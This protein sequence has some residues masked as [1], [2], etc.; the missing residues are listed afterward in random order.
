MF[1]QVIDLPTFNEVSPLSSVTEDRPRGY[2][3]KLTKGTIIPGFINAAT[4]QDR[5]TG[6]I[7][8]LGREMLGRGDGVPDPSNSTLLTCDRYGNVL[9]RKV[10]V[11]PNKLGEQF[12][13]WRADPTN[14]GRVVLGATWTAKIAEG[15][16]RPQMA[17]TEVP[18]NWD[19]QFGEI[20]LVPEA[21]YGK[22]VTP[23][24]G[25]K[26][27]LF[28][29]DR[30]PHVL[31][32]YIIGGNGLVYAGEVHMPS[33]VRERFVKSG[34]TF[35]P[36]TESDGSGDGLIHV[37]EMIGSKLVYSIRKVRVHMNGRLSI[38]EVNL[39]EAITKADF[40]FN[41]PELRQD[42][43]IEVV[44]MTGAFLYNVADQATVVA[45]FPR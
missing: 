45:G 37:Q 27:M 8:A 3:T 10:V 22:N 35:G 33:S 9:E 26:R 12:E 25:G 28:R 13:D 20:H 29:P 42:F 5:Q 15:D 40:H 32:D 1:E 17:W 41:I 7:F 23:W 44:Y 36:R 14:D 21:G 30:E 34:T 16:Y 24:F 31:D 6:K 4:W 11:R 2:P 43:P 38:T 18:P 19:G 39:E